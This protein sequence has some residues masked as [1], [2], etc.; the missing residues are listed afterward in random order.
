MDEEHLHHYPK[1]MDFKIGDKN[2]RKSVMKVNNIYALLLAVD[3]GVGLAALPDYMTIGKPGLVKV[4]GEINGPKYEAHFVFP[5][6][7]KNVA[8]VQAFRDFIFN[9]VSEWQF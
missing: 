9:K 4:L 3:S 8:R 2:K 6:S 1:R 5:Q 7:L